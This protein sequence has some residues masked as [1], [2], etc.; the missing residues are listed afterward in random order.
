MGRGLFEVNRQATD[1]A[2]YENSC[3]STLSHHCKCLL[4]T[5]QDVYKSLISFNQLLAIAEEFG[6]VASVFLFFCLPL[7]KSIVL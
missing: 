4:N 7:A 3:S 6:L 2:G 5:R 1:K